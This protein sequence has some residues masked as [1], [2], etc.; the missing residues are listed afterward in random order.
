MSSVDSPST[1]RTLL[2]LLRS[3]AVNE[4]AW[5]TFIARYTPMIDRWCWR[6]RLQAADADEVK[7]RV[8]ATLATALKEFHYDPARRFRGWLK[9]IVNNAVRSYWRERTAKPG[10]IGSGDDAVHEQ[11][12]Q[13][14]LPD[15]MRQLAEELD[16]SVQHDLALANRIITYVKERV[17]PRTWEAYWLTTMENVSASDVAERLGMNVTAVYMA[18]SRVGKRLREA[19]K[20]F[21]AEQQTRQ[22]P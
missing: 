9:T 21:Q 3:S 13:I 16:Q 18:K 6:A 20:Q 15:P 22:E 12:E 4:R 7:G 17:E 8:L 19:A 5:E 14:E 11:L 10:A 1:S 2:E